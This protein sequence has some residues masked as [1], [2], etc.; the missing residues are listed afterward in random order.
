M[1]SGSLLL[2]YAIYF[3]L[4][5]CIWYRALPVANLL[6]S[7]YKWNLSVLFGIYKTGGFISLHLISSNESCCSFPQLNGLHFLVKLYIGFN[8]FCSSGQNILRKFTI[9]AKLQHPFAVLGGVVF[10]L[11]P[12]C[13]LRVA[14][15]LFFSE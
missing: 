8:N 5:F 3:G 13:F 12:I 6:V 11:P 14:H 9:P 2:A 1:A 4:P 7:K 15:T 10:E